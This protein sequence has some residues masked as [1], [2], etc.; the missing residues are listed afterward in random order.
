MDYKKHIGIPAKRREFRIRIE[1]KQSMK[2]RIEARPQGS[3][4]G[5]FSFNIYMMGTPNLEHNKIRDD[6]IKTLNGHGFH[7]VHIVVSR[8]Y[9]IVNVTC[10][11]KILKRY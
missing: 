4:V 2:R 11:I 3:M 9:N 1:T 6:T 8:C 5:P 7:Y 10:K